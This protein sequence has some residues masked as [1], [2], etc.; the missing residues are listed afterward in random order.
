M[1]AH[2]SLA[3]CWSFTAP[4]LLGIAACASARGE[5]RWL[6]DES[7]AETL[8]TE[9]QIAASG[10]ATAWDAIRQHARHLNTSER[11]DGSPGRIQRRGRSS[12][13]LSDA[14]LIFVD[15]VRVSDFRNLEMIPARDVLWIRIL[16]GIEATTH[17]GTNAGNGVILVQTKS[18]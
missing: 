12:I 13:Y 2:C 6:E 18:E 3:S 15:G 14:P 4:L 16:S 10:A 8:I 1:A 7:T 9:E 11:K 5:A 17:Y